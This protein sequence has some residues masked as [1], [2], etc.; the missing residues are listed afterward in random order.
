[1]V[2]PSP[3]L[4]D[5]PG[6]LDMGDFSTFLSGDEEADEDEHEPEIRFSCTVV[7]LRLT[8]P[9]SKMYKG[10]SSLSPSVSAYFKKYFILT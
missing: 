9:E 8:N 2:P 1:L 4:L 6:S 5:D 7:N 3:P 10:E